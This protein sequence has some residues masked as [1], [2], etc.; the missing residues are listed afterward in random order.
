MSSTQTTPR[1]ATTT[2]VPV[3]DLR[4]FWRILFAVLAPLAPLAAMLGA[5]IQPWK[6]SAEP[7]DMIASIAANPGAQRI[8]T[9]FDVLAAG[10]AI[11]SILALGWATRRRAPLLTAI[12]GMLCAFGM[13]IQA[14]LPSVDLFALAGI[15]KGVDH[16]AL[17][18]IIAGVNAHPIETVGILG[19]L[20][21]HVVGQILLGIA[22]W[23]TRIAPWWFG[24][25]LIVSGPLQM[26][27][28]GSNSVAI[29]STGWFLNAVVF[30]AATYALLRVPN[31]ELDLAPL[32]R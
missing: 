23:R 21:G 26:V 11:V 1:P 19:F 3:R 12:G 32:A 10:L 29:A 5:L 2:G 14:Q 27:G 9:W 30:A 31:D 28:G 16:E 7:K 24:L 8:A 25:A 15:D 22:V 4:G 17:A 6:Y 20:L 13:L 18:T